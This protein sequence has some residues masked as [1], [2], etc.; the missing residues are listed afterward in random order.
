MGLEAV[1]RKLCANLEQ[2]QSEIELLD[3]QL[4]GEVLKLFRQDDLAG[5][6]KLMAKR[7]RETELS[8]DVRSLLEK[9]ADY[10]TDPNIASLDLVQHGKSL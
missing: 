1:L 3:D 6:E 8:E 7:R 5:I 2:V 9:W 10:L 4:K